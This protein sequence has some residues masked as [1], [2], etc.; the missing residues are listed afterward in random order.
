MDLRSIEHISRCS[1]S[2]GMPATAADA[3]RRRHREPPPRCLRGQGRPLPLVALSLL[4]ALYISTSSRCSVLPCQLHESCQPGRNGARGKEAR[5]SVFCES[6]P[7]LGNPG[8][9]LI[10]RGFRF[11]LEIRTSQFHSA[12]PAPIPAA[13]V[14]SVFIAHYNLQRSGIGECCG[15]SREGLGCSSSG[16]SPL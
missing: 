7:F 15:A 14:V 16:W 9:C 13:L 3:A 12:A 6:F 11:L 4:I 8:T 10:L 2:D 1:E 5:Y